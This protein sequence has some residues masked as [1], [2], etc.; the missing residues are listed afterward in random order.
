MQH[1]GT[2]TPKPKIRKVRI[3]NKYFGR[4]KGYA[5]FPDIRLCGKWL[6]ESGYR[7]GQYILIDHNEDRIIITRQPQEP[8]N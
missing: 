4:A 2:E 8:D 6:M 5:I 1:D 7:S 3:C